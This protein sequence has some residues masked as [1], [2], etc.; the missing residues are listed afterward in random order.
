MLGG[1][2]QYDQLLIIGHFYARGVKV[3]YA[4]EKREC[5]KED[6]S[7]VKDRVFCKKK[8]TRF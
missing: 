8:N 2:A 3:V 5:I 4:C 1:D 7:N 6:D